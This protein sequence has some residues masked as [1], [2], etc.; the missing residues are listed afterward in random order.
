MNVVAARRS[1][2]YD[3]FQSNAA[4]Q[5]FFFASANEEVYVAY[6][7]SMYLLQDS[8]ESLQLHLARGFSGDALLAYLELWGVL[9]AAV[10]QLNIWMRSCKAPVQTNAPSVDTRS[11]SRSRSESTNSNSRMLRTLM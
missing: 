2:I 9:Q 4:C 1:E 11:A 8:T 5:Q 7:N 6:Y 10:I 3:H